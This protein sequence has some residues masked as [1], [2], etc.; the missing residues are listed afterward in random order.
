MNAANKIIHTSIPFVR[1]WIWTSFNQ[2]D[3]ILRFSLPIETT[4]RV[5]GL[6]NPLTHCSPNTRR[7]FCK[8]EKEFRKIFHLHIGTNN[9]RD[10]YLNGAN[11][12]RDQQKNEEEKVKEIIWAEKIFRFFRFL[13]I[14]FFGVGVISDEADERKKN[15]L[16]SYHFVQPQQ[17]RIWLPST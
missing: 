8:Q 4:Q 1:F 6:G 15:F 7:S 10:W 3:F 12:Q 13:Y 14:F 16:R 9:K 11:E 5:V 17:I 2:I